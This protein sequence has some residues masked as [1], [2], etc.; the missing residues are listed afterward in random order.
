MAAAA[1][2]PRYEVGPDDDTMTPES[3]LPLTT[4]GGGED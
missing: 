2:Y 4:P 3:L 1:A